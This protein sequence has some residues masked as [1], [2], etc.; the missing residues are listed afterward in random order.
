MAPAGTL[1]SPS[2]QLSTY[3][4]NRSPMLRNLAP[5]LHLGLGVKIPENWHEITWIFFLRNEW[6]L[7]VRSRS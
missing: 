1:S 5:K 3:L 7:W 4:G 6:G 2:C